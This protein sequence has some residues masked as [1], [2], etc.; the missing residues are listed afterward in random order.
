METVEHEGAVAPEAARY[1][2]F[3]DDREYHVTTPTIT[4]SQI[5]ALA[6][7]PAETGLILLLSDGTQRSVPPNETFDLRGEHHFKKPP[8]FKRG[9]H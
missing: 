8:R 9:A 1:T 5:M 6:G 3:V 2:F 4:G 7:I